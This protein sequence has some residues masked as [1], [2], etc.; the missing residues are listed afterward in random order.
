MTIQEIESL[1]AAIKEKDA[2]IRRI[3]ESALQHSQM[4]EADLKQVEEAITRAVKA[5]SRLE[6]LSALG[7]AVSEDALNDLESMREARDE[8][9]RQMNR[10]VQ[11]A[12]DWE[13]TARDVLKN[14]DFWRARSEAYEDL[15]YSVVLYIQWTYVTRQLTTEQR[16]LFA[17]GLE[18]AHD[19]AHG[20][21]GADPD[22]EMAGLPSYA[23]RWWRD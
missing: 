6:R 3:S 14:S 1:Q 13:E 19:R 10:A 18:R 4:H 5:E 7:V 11:I 20:P 8:A 21:D 9:E 17:D 2:I 15:L 12:G 22:P 23:S 16:E